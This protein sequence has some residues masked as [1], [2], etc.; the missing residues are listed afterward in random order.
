MST[1]PSS[2][3][4]TPDPLADPPPATLAT[5]L[6]RLAGLPGLPAR[7]RNDLA[8]AVRSFCRAV[9]KDPAS[10][11]AHPPT[12]RYHAQR[13][14]PARIGVSWGRWRN[15]VAGV[16]RALD[17]THCRVTVR[18]LDRQLSGR[19]KDL[20][21]C[22]PTSLESTAFNRLARYSSS[23]GV[24]PSQV[25]DALIGRFLDELDQE[26]LMKDPGRTVAAVCRAW[27]KARLCLP[28]WPQ[29]RLS[30]PSKSRSY[31]LSWPDFP[32]SLHHEVLAYHRRSLEPDPVD[33]ESPRPVRP[34]T[35]RLRNGQLLRLATAEVKRGIPIGDLKGLADLVKPERLR[36]G[37]RFWI[38]PVT[39]GPV[40]PDRPVTKQVEAMALLARSIARHVVKLPK[41]NLDELDRLY[42]RLRRKREGMTSKNRER[43]GRLE[44]DAIIRSLLNLPAVLARRADGAP[45]NRHAAL[46]M[47]TAVAIELLLVT[48]IR[49]GNLCHL[50]YGDNFR[51]AQFQGKREL[52]LIIPAREVKNRVDLE[53]PLPPETTALVERY[54]SQYQPLLTH[55]HTSDALF[56]GHSGGPKR[57]NG[58]WLQITRTTLSEVGERV[59]PHLF[60]H[61]GA[62]LHLKHRPGEYEVMRRVLAH[63]SIA[64]TMESYVGLETP[65]A[66]R[67][68]DETILRQRTD[69]YVPPRRPR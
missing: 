69:R 4:A 43:L 8:S 39:N 33:P 42:R 25:D 38:P 52:H 30:M 56:P 34:T 61:L 7:V 44:D 57:P 64:T 12:L 2:R 23:L 17:L 66:L 55:G 6:E 54:M 10:L 5:V 18:Q 65:D 21:S 36:E 32:A 62:R 58:L 45:A 27:N 20:L 26:S 53:C 67:H 16:N 11:A 15:I 59:N 48:T 31:A 46:V 9:G 19:W 41:E 1:E 29:T 50:T 22:F 3:Q 14:V 51:S 60:R 63:R 49:L 28:G 68:F 13:V 35:V 37:L 47:Q 24:D 40:D